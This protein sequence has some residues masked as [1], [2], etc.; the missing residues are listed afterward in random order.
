VVDTAAATRPSRIIAAF[1]VCR[2]AGIKGND[3]WIAATARS[4]GAMLVTFDASLAAR[5]ATIGESTLL[6]L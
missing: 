2:A 3:A 4:L 5:Y 6:T 1:G